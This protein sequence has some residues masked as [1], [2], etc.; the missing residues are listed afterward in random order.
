M[1]INSDFCKK[2]QDE[3]NWV[4][5]LSLTLYCVNKIPA[6]HCYMSIATFVESQ[7]STQKVIFSVTPS[8]LKYFDLT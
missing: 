2:L 3:C 8:N 4:V 1:Y 6:G 7:H 5:F